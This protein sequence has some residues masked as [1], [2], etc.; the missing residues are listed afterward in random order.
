M[1]PIPKHLKGIFQ[2]LGTKNSEFEVVGKLVCDCNSED[3]AIEFVGD[4]HKY[5]WHKAIRVARIGDGYFL[6]VKVECNNC[7]KE[8]LIFDNDYHGWNGYIGGD[9][10][11]LPRPETK[12]WNC[13]KCNQTS[14]S[15]NLAINSKGQED[16]K[17]EAGD[18][19]PMEDWIEAFSW[20]T[21]G[22]ECKSCRKSNKE[23]ISYETM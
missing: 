7:K 22:I 8:H 15:I 5:W 9:F 4:D 3:F 13:K 21:I 10:R 20:I 12:D 18:E 19:C 16:F 11:E 6:I 17:Q 23:W 1:L 14:H 2:P